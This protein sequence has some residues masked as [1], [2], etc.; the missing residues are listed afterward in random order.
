MKIEQEIPNLSF[1]RTLES[2]VFILANGEKSKDT[3][4]SIKNVE[5][6]RRRLRK[7]Q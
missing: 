6:D 3:G 1:P 7:K 2:R 4:S 5:D